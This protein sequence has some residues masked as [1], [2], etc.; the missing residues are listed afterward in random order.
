MENDTHD[1]L[2]ITYL[3]YFKANEKFEQ[4]PSERTKRT[5]RREL[6]KLIKLAKQRQDEI[7]ERYQQE[8]EIIRASNKWQSNRTK[9]KNKSKKA[10]KD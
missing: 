3:D 9:N 8:L 1:Q 7:Y 2:V 4:G 10:N 6:R 5:A